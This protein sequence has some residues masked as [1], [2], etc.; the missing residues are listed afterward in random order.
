MSVVSKKSFIVFLSFFSFV[1]ICFIG[2]GEDKSPTQDEDTYPLTVTFDSSST[3][4]NL[5]NFR[6]HIIDGEEAVILADLVDTSIVIYPQNYAY[7]IVGED[8]FYAHMKGDPDNTWE[9]LQSGYIILSRMSSCFDPSLELPGRYYVKDTAEMEIL[10]KIDFV[11]PADS[12]IQFVV[13]EMT[14]TAFEDSLTG[15]ALSEFATPV[16]DGDPPV[17]SYDLVAADEYTKTI[18][19]EQILE[20]YYIIELDR[21]FYANSEV[22]SSLKIKHLNRIIA[23]NPP[24]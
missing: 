23:F 8:G 1:L 14:L 20:G 18:N 13:D 4:M 17:Y 10:R 21:V 2:C 6:K 22:P 16:I 12:L 19:Y 24:D 5:D 11:T 7:R 15:I 3:V 9:Q